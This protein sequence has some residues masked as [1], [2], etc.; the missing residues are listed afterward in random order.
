M[1]QL[2]SGDGLGQ[3]RD[4]GHRITGLPS[5]RTDRLADREAA[6]REP[7]FRLSR[8]VGIGGDNEPDDVIGAK[9]ALGWAGYYPSDLAQT[10]TADASLEGDP[11]FLYGIRRFQADSGLSADSF[12]RRDGET[13]TALNSRITPLVLAAAPAAPA[14]GRAGRC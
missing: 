1:Q 5:G 4:D 10:P 9:R 2:R 8:S 12:M 13:A 3:A 11:Q 6:G 7:V 14:P